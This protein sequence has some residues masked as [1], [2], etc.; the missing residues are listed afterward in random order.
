[1]TDTLK[2]YLHTLA[3]PA[4]HTRELLFFFVENDWVDIVDEVVRCVQ[5]N[6]AYRTQSQVIARDERGWFI[7]GGVAGS[8]QLTGRAYFDQE[9]LIS[10]LTGAAPYLSRLDD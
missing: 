10:I 9:H 1:M 5:T 7:T 8:I 4:L 6:Q 2:R 3:L